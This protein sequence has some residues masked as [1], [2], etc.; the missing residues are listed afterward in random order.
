MLLIKELLIKKNMCIIVIVSSDCSIFGPIVRINRHSI[1][2]SWCTNTGC[3][4]ESAYHVAVY[5]DINCR[6]W[7]YWRRDLH[8]YRVILRH[9]IKDF[10]ESFQLYWATIRIFRIR[11]LFP[12]HFGPRGTFTPRTFFRGELYMIIYPRKRLIYLEIL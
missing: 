12:V 8:L 11:K 2:T 9:T 4:S 1:M 6:W 3:L 7:T 10:Y 5:G